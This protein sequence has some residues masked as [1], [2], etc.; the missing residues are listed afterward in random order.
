MSPRRQR[1]EKVVQHRGKELDKRIS[2]LNEQ[3]NREEAA[4][5]AAQRER[6]EAARASENRLKMAQAPLSA[7]DWIAANEWLKSRAALAEIA[8]TQAVKA[9]LVTQRARAEV[10]HA[11]TDLKKVEVLS[12]RIGAEERVRQERAERR[13]EDE[14]A[15]QRIAAARRGEK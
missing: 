2:E 9:R 4:R 6:E 7:T 10:L 14:L 11:R 5:M 1:I 15:A 3:K 12:A 8:E 13:L